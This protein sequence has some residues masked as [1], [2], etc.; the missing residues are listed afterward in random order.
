[1]WGPAIGRKE[2]RENF[3]LPG[4]RKIRWSPFSQSREMLSGAHS[5]RAIRLALERVPGP[6][7]KYGSGMPCH[8]KHGCRCSADRQVCGVWGPFMEAGCGKEQTQVLVGE[9]VWSAS[10]GAPGHLCVQS[11]SVGVN[12]VRGTNH[13]WELLG[14][15][16]KVSLDREV[17]S[18]QHFF[19]ALGW[20]FSRVGSTAYSLLVDTMFISPN[21][22]LSDH[23]CDQGDIK[24][25]PWET[26]LFIT[27]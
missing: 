15:R 6:H 14:G 25:S 1:M 18:Q 27:N 3:L 2:L 11:T 5:N 9:G 22:T 10:Q 16:A 4:K 13:P 20:P 24:S 12:R 19:R 26:P 21:G 7:D 17:R 8:L 23:E